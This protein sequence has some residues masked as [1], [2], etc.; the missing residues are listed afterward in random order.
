MGGAQPLPD[1]AHHPHGGVVAFGRHEDVVFHGQEVVEKVLRAG[2]A[3][4]AGDAHHDEVRHGLEAGAGV[5]DVA[6]GNMLFQRM[7]DGVRQPCPGPD[8]E[9]EQGGE[10]DGPQVSGE[11]GEGQHSGQQKSLGGQ[12]PAHPVG[13]HQGLFGLFG[14]VQQAGEQQDRRRR[15]VAPDDRQIHGGNEQNRQDPADGDQLCLVVPAPFAVPLIPVGIELEHVGKI[16]RLHPKVEGAGD[17]HGD[18][19]GKFH[20]IQ[21][22]LL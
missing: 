22:F 14:Q 18:F 15:A 5:L 2:L 21:P 9:G 6:A 16:Q 19:R 7:I 13:K 3:I 11:E 1:S 17:K 20:G 4:A 8:D 12:K 10:A